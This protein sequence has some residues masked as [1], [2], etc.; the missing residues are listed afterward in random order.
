MPEFEVHLQHSGYDQRLLELRNE[1]M[2][3]FLNNQNSKHYFDLFHS[4]MFI[5]ICRLDSV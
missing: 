1:A 2:E 5:A 3:V 4:F